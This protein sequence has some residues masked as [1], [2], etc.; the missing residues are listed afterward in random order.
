MLRMN[1]SKKDNLALEDQL[2]NFTDQ[3]LEK[4]TEENTP[5]FDQDPELRALQQTA[6]RL[7][8]ALHDDGPGEAAIQRMHQNILLEW[9]QRESQ[10]NKSIWRR[11]SALLKPREQS[12]QSQRNRQRWNTIMSLAG[13]AGVMLMSIFLLNKGDF[14]Q[15]AASGQNL[16][17]GVLAVTSVLILLVLWIFRRKL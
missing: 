17:S 1:K 4:T 9:K 3:I 12:W 15:P 7:K 14:E 5:T 13:V 6:Q 11:L 16:N 8:N 2:A 10:A